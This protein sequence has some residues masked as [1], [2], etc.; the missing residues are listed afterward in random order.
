MESEASLV[1]RLRDRIVGGLHRG[2]S[3]RSPGTD[4]GYRT[5]D[6]SECRGR[7]QRVSDVGRCAHCSKPQIRMNAEFAPSLKVLQIPLQRTPPVPAGLQF[8][9]AARSTSEGA[10]SGSLRGSRGVSAGSLARGRELHLLTT[11]HAQQESFAT[12]LVNVCPASLI[13]SAQVRYGCR[14]ETTS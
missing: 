8:G 10:D 1:E 4:P 13:P 14:V 2:I 12:S 5:A 11:A 7:G 3:R 6:R 9:S